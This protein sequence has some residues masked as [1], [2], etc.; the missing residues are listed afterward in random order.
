MKDYI[1]SAKLGVMGGAI[2]FLLFFFT[3]LIL[4]T[5][6][7]TIVEGTIIFFVGAFY[8]FWII[9]V[10][11]TMGINRYISNNIHQGLIFWKRFAMIII[12]SF[13]CFISYIQGM[14][15]KKILHL[16]LCVRFLRNEL[17]CF[18]RSVIYI[19]ITLLRKRFIQ[20]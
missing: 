1:F 10:L 12:F 6:G 18:L 9:V 17:L 16:S 14:F 3:S 4:Q 15:I 8:L 7:L 11:G 13:V 2:F 20:F 5:N 19:N